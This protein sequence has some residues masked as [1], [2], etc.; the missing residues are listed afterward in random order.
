MS[1]SVSGAQGASPWGGVSGA[2]P[3]MPPQQKMSS[4]F[5]KIDSNGSGSIS[6]SQFAS[7]FQSFNPPAA[8]KNAG[9]DAIWSQLDPSGSG[10]VSQQDFV[11]RMKDLMVKLR[12]GNTNST[13]GAQTASTATSSLVNLLA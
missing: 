11:T 9:S 3:Q 5:S 13:A 2:S 1:I 12:Q 10:Q 8:F 6:E 7:A 4:L